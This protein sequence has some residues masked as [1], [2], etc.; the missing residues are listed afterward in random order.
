MRQPLRLLRFGTFELDLKTGELRRKGA[1]VALQE[2]PFR[3]LAMLVE[4]AGDLVTRDDLRARL[5][6]DAV[7]LDFDQGLNTAVLKIRRALGDLADSPRYVETLE[8]RGYRFLAAIEPVAATPEREDADDGSTSLRVFWN[9]R[10]IPLCEGSNIIGRDTTAL[11]YIDSPDVSRRHAQIVV[12]GRSAVLQEL[13][14]KNGTFLNERRVEAAAL[15]DGDII[16]IGRAA[17]IFRSAPTG[18]PTR[19]S[20]K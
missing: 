19:S 9:D 12:S 4:R 1:R 7:F 13:G 5:W 3:V 8:R 6:P 17:L 20:V 14:S 15:S 2:Q 16:R 10:S 18:G 11:V